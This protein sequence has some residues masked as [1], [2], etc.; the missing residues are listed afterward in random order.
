MRAFV[1]FR[2]P[3]GSLREL[4]PGETLGRAWSAGLILD[5]GRI[6]EAH[7][8]VSLRGGELKLLALRGRFAVAGRPM[9]ELAL[10]AG[11]RIELARD[12]CLDVEAVALPDEVLGLEGDGLARRIL[13]PVASLYPGPRSELVAGF[14]PDAP[15]RLWSAWDGWRLVVEPEPPRGLQVGD[16][17]SWGG[18]TF[19]AVAVPLSQASSPTTR[20]G[21][22]VDAP[23]RLVVRFDSV[24]CFADEELVAVL[25]GV[26]ARLVSELVAM[27]GTVDWEILARE[28]WA[29]EDDRAALRRRFDVALVRLR[30]KLRDA[31]LRPDLVGTNGSGLLELRLSAHDRVDEQQ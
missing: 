8:L 25:G 9:S 29:D 12:L 27:G 10:A 30:Q 31:R 11:Q 15:V 1:R 22:S 20:G 21:G 4:V 16:G 3:D 23:L 28:L 17:F 5:D 2:L 13:P 19:R 18:R 26:S 24:H 14:Q 6:S 7:A